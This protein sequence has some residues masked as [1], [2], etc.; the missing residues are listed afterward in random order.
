M[1]DHL[2]RYET[3]LDEARSSSKMP[4]DYLRESLPHLWFD[5]YAR[6]TPRSTNVMTFTHGTFDYFYD[7]LATLEATGVV[8]TDCVS[9]SRLVA[10]VGFSRPNS[11]S[12]RQDD[13]RLRGWVGPTNKTFGAGW[14]KGHFIAH[15]IGGA[16]DGLEANIFLQRRSVNRGAYRKLERY[17]SANPG[18]L[19]FSRPIYGDPSARSVR[20]EFGVLRP[21]ASWWIELLDNV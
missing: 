10:A 6:M 13:G 5:E 14:D 12:R 3:L 8:P 2:L 15:S 18:A 20:V 9:E 17:C 4:R 1:P 19:C 11:V 16:V 21:D 7:D